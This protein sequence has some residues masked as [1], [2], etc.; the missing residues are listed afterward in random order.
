[1]TFC[2]FQT[3]SDRCRFG[4]ET[5]GACAAWVQGCGVGVARSR[6]FLGGVGVGFPT[7]LGVGVGFL[8]DSD[9]GS[10]IESFFTSHS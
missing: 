4:T 2:G 10:A 3:H 5:C 7:T 9:S 1:M 6:R 8:S